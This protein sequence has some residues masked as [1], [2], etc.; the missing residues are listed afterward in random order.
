L[1]RL[2]GDPETIDFV[3][4]VLA[5][6]V[7]HPEKKLELALVFVG[8][9]GLGKSTMLHII[10]KL[11][12]EANCVWP[13]ARQLD[14]TFT[15]GY[16]NAFCVLWDE[17]R[18]APNKATGRAEQAR[19]LITASTFQD[20]RKGADP[21]TVPNPSFHAFCA[22]DDNAMQVPKGDRRL[23]VVQMTGIRD[24]EEHEAWLKKG[25]WPWL[26]SGGFEAILYELERYELGD[27]DEHTRPPDTIGKQIMHEASL[28]DWE[29]AMLEAWEDGRGPFARD[30]V[31][32]EALMHWYKINFFKDVSINDI[33]RFLR[34]NGAIYA[35][36]HVHPRM[37]MQILEAGFIRVVDR[38]VRCWVI[39]DQEDFQRYSYSETLQQKW[40][41]KRASVSLSKAEAAHAQ[42]LQEAAFQLKEEQND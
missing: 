9:G 3:K 25:F 14:K 1:R 27:F 19:R 37:E 34:S 12:G 26:K 13:D 22:N 42:R 24:P 10:A 29:A 11:V 5:W 39:R 41:Q 35:G 31:S 23:C 4:K 8:P 6:L 38:Q 21:V 2:I 28:E 20:E 40:A 30:V 18:G 7:Q 32:V 36:R 33:R 15:G 17:I 16:A